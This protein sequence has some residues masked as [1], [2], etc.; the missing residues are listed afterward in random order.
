MTDDRDRLVE[1]GL[2]PAEAKR[3]RELLTKLQRDGLMM[4]EHELARQCAA[5]R[6]RP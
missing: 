1:A 5:S 2:T 4:G 3:A 6:V